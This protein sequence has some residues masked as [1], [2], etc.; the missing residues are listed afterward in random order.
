MITA[1]CIRP[2]SWV[3]SRRLRTANSASWKSCLLQGEQYPPLYPLKKG[4]MTRGCSPRGAWRNHRSGET[5]GKVRDVWSLQTGWM[6]PPNGANGGSKHP[7]WNN[8]SLTTR[9]NNEQSEL[10]EEELSTV[11]KHVKIHVMLVNV[12]QSWSK[13]VNG[14]SECRTFA[15]SEK[16]SGERA[17]CAALQS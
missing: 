4:G 17:K 6:E 15:P 10:S 9:S 5:G 1:S 12:G 8:H 11:K 3:S 13:L 2:R 16:I 7:E 14:F